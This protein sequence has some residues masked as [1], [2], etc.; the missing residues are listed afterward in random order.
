MKKVI[1]VLIFLLSPII[2]HSQV[3]L[4]KE[5][6]S[7]YNELRSNGVDAHFTVSKYGNGDEYLRASDEVMSYEFFFDDN[8]ICTTNIIL[9][10]NRDIVY[11]ICDILGI[12]LDWNSHNVVY[13]GK[14][15]RAITTKIRQEDGLLYNIT[16]RLLSQ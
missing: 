12:P 4:G 11:T 7:L 10:Y 1:I 5:K 9:T 2:I 15:I 13:N 3:Y 8:N 16:L 6:R 14:K